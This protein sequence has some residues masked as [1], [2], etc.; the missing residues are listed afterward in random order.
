MSSSYRV[1]LLGPGNLAS[2]ACMHGVPN[3]GTRE[4]SD[5]HER[6]VLSTDS[7]ASKAINRVIC[8]HTPW[9]LQQSHVVRQH[10]TT[11]V[12][13]NEIK[14][15]LLA[16]SCV[17]KWIGLCYSLNCLEYGGHKQSGV[18]LKDAS[19]HRWTACM[20]VPNQP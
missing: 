2:L 1:T 17:H 20:F 6:F 15:A 9:L 14:S 8:Y 7:L 18:V 16:A 10:H 13:S 3:K 5:D 4:H 11:T 19:H 12:A